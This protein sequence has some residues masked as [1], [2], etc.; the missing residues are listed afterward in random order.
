MSRDFA[1]IKRLPPYVFNVVGELKMAARRRG[2]DIIDLSMGN[3][4]GAT[5]RHIV[6]KATEAL[7]KPAN[8]RY[9][10]S[11]GLYKLRL[12][13]C[14]WYR[15]K[16][17]IELDADAEMICTMGA[18]EGLGHLVLTLVGPGDT[19]VCPSPTY[20]IH[21]YSVVIAGA[22]LR[23]VPLLPGQDF[24]D[25][26]VEAVRDAWPRPK[27]LILSFPANPTTAV[28]DL[29]FFERVVEFARDNDLM[30]IHDNAYAELVFDGYQAP[31]LLQVPGAKEVGV[32]LYTL[33]KTYNMPGWRVGFV[34]GNAEMIAALARVKSYYDYGMFNPV[35]IA[36][37]AALN[38]PQDCVAEIVAT[39]RERRDSLIAGL[40]RVGWEVPSPKATM[41]VWARIPDEFV[42]MGS[43]EFTK[44]VLAEAKVAV[45]PGIGFGPYGDEYV[46]FALIEN[47]HRMRQAIRGL[48]R[49]FGGE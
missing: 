23:H 5:P 13:A 39:Y 9:S 19:V 49:L 28:V 25:S 2:E 43:L 47:P 44:L 30:V 10:V 6:E 26:L 29:S 42:K 14:D 15:R 17:G 38:G 21:Q 36:A 3:P 33:S 18:K 35:Q 34:A 7:T 37:I 1:R 22:D 48:R 40:A 8:H 24:F 27:L 11:R 46:R 31:S 4:D 32:E 16:W 12:A 45:S 41:F 20:P